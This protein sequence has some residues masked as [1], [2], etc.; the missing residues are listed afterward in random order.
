MVSLV[1]R[2]AHTPVAPGPNEITVGSFRDDAIEVLKSSIDVE[3]IA[4]DGIMKTF[5]DQYVKSWPSSDPVTQ[6]PMSGT[7]RHGT[8]LVS[9][10][11][12]GSSSRTHS[13]WTIRIVTSQI[14]ALEWIYTWWILVCFVRLPPP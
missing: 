3:Y 1:R 5:V 2:F 9:V 11:G 7:T 12:P 4:E 13:L 6:T 8:W 14:Q 10:L